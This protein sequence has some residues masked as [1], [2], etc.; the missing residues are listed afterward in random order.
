MDVKA[1]IQSVR[2]K[3]EVEMRFCKGEVGEGVGVEAHDRTV[4]GAG[5]IEV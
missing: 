5:S 4:T 2:Q 1:A 3:A